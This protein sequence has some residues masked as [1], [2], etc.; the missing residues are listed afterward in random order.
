MENQ[1]TSVQT[2]QQ[3]GQKEYWDLITMGSGNLYDIRVYQPKKG[4]AMLCTRIKALC[5]H[6]DAIEP[7]WFDVN[8]TG[9]KAKELISQCIAASKAKCKIFVRFSVGDIYIDS[10]SVMHGEDAGKTRTVFKGRLLKIF[11]LSI[12]RQ[13][14]YRAPKQIVQDEGQCS[15]SQYDQASEAP[16]ID[17]PAEAVSDVTPAQ[18]HFDPSATDDQMATQPDPQ[19]D[20]LLETVEQF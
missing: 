2:Q 9:E 6:K 12:D 13:V 7:R 17:I 8:V 3:S 14:K 20:Q 19:T 10:Y 16:G 1:T 11:M 4:P 18:S 5:G 15:S